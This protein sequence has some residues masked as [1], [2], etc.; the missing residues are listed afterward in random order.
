MRAV[1]TAT[2]ALVLGVERKSLDN[3]LNRI[4]PGAL[5]RGRQGV[6]RRI[7]IALLETL[8]ITSDLMATLGSPARETFHVARLI[9]A[10]EGARAQLGPFVSVSVDLP[11]LRRELNERLEQAI[12]RVVRRPRGRPRGRPPTR[13]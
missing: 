7:P 4:D 10:A 9:A 2:A 8:A 13:R 6:E 3:L 5:P 11:S 1:T 12:E